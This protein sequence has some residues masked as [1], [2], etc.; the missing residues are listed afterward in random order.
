VADASV[1]KWR[2]RPLTKDRSV[3]A[4]FLYLSPALLLFLGFKLWPILYN[5]VLSFFSWNFIGPMRW[6]RIKNYLGMFQRAEFQAALGNTLY[7]IFGLLPFFLALPL[8]LAVLLSGIESK[9][10]QDAYK[11]LFFFPTILALSIICLVWMWMFNPN[12]GVLNALLSLLGAKGISWLSDRRTALFSIIL[13]SGWK[14]MGAHMILFYA[15]L[16]TVPREYVEAATIDGASPWQLFWR[17]KWP[18]LSP[19]TIYIALTSV[20]FAAERAFIPIDVLTQGGPANSTTN[21]SHVIYRFGFEYFNIGLA[22]AAAI[23]TSVFF[24]AIAFVMMR[25]L[26]GYGYN[27]A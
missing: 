3:V 18:L 4:F 22:S 7:Y 13:V 15:G 11:A 26:E 10:A 20:I 1:G 19:T 27:A 9:K 14:F 8:L 25:T 2:R 5:L 16:M 24:L 12:F 17:I 21:L 23:F 6:V